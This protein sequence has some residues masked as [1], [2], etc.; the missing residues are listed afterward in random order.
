MPLKHTVTE[1]KLKNGAQGLIIDV[2]DSTVVAFR[3]QFRAGYQYVSDP[4]KQQAA[5]IM[6]HMAFGANAKFD[7]PEA[8]SQEFSKNGAYSNAMT[9]D[10]DMIYVAW[11]AHM[12]W[13]RILDLLELSITQPVF[14]QKILDA[15]KGNVREE[16]VS[17]A[18]NHGRVLWGRL[19]RAMGSKNAL[20]TEKLASVEKV[21]LKDIQEHHKYTHTLNNLRFIIVG[22]LA[23]HHDIVQEKL[24]RWSLSAGERFLARQESLHSTSPLSIHRDD[25]SNIR[26]ALSIT[27]NREFSDAEKDAMGALNHILTGTFHSRIFGTARTNGWCY[28]MGSST[29]S[30]IV[31]GTFWEFYGQVGEQN[32]DQ[33]FE[34]ITDQLKQI[35]NG[36][37][38]ATELSEAKQYALGRYQTGTQTVHDIANWYDDP[39]F[40]KGQ[41]DP[42]TS[43]PAMIE[44]VKREHIIELAREFIEQGEWAFGT[45]GNMSPEVTE[46]LNTIIAKVL[47]PE[48]Q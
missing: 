23:S 45:I 1:V 16:L 9:N 6:E 10:R 36:K 17:N 24:E 12:E 32:A 27:L 34:L 25:M 39:Y 8:F 22:D 21:T 3:F 28:G 26:F 40:D 15:E 37:L 33:L 38:T 11:S 31:G 30:D 47:K 7:S 5:H 43:S 14:T 20:D 13:Q 4:A 19:Y 18:N 35:I 46:K 48:V 2:P 42:L 29:S 41:I 44:A